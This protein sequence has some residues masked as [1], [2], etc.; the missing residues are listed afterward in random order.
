VSKVN[1]NLVLYTL[2]D[3]KYQSWCCLIEKIKLDNIKH[4]VIVSNRFAKEDIF[5]I[6]NRVVVCLKNNFNDCIQYAIDAFDWDVIP[7]L[8]TFRN[9]ATY[10]AGTIPIVV[11]EGELFCLLGIDKRRMMYSDFGGGF[12]KTFKTHHL[13]SFKN[14]VLKEYR[15][16]NGYINPSILADHIAESAD[17]TNH[18]DIPKITTTTDISARNRVDIFKENKAIGF[19]DLNTKYVAFREMFEETTYIDN[20]NHVTNS[21]DLD[22]MFKKLYI[23]K[24]Y[25]YLGGDLNYRYD[26][27]VIFYTAN[28]LTSNMR[29]WFIHQYAQYVSDQTKYSN[30]LNTPITPITPIN[31]TLDHVFQFNQNCEMVGISMIPLKFITDETNTI[32]Y[33]DYIQSKTKTFK[34]DTLLKNMRTSFTDAMIRYNSELSAL[35]APSS[36]A[37]FR[38]M[39]Q[40]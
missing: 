10:S 35:T 13:D 5:K 20:Y 1:Q 34:E 17:R 24:T 37:K 23:D 2:S 21:F 7:K 39:L 27:F 9:P 36:F 19:G 8:N 12:D 40:I 26:T 28:E 22:T 4:V 6:T 14:D 15:I 29:E 38:N 32:R 16:K 3:V 30:M 25:M 11:Y 18:P 31:G 33:N